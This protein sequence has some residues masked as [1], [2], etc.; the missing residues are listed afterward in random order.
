LK[1]GEKAGL[2]EELR[3]LSYAEDIQ[4]VAA[5]GTQLISESERSVVDQ[6]GNIQHQ[7]NALSHA[8]PDFPS[9]GERL[10]AVI[11]ELDDIA[12]ELSKISESVEY[13]PELAKELQERIDVLNRLEA[14][15]MV[16]DA[17]E[18]IEIHT[19]FEA[20]LSIFEDIE[21]AIIN[22]E[23]ELSQKESALNKLATELT[24]K[25]KAV[26]SPIEKK[27]QESLSLLNMTQA[28]LKIQLKASVKYQASGRD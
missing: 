17:D 19:T 9:L 10:N 20:Q 18:L 16:Q 3:I 23:K 25:R 1:K 13:N 5:A 11:I 2:T 27:I 7:I 8:Y 12:S 21:N 4:K 6:L 15:H 24:Q 28:E 22:A 14:K 26:I